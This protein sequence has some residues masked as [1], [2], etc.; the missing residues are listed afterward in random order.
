MDDD[1]DA[2]GWRKGMKGTQHRITCE[3]CG[4]VFTAWRPDTLPGAPVKC[5]F[6]GHSFSDE[7]AKRPPLPAPP[8]APPPAAPTAEPKADA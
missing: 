3:K 5:Y 4:K 7:A 6:C 8:A 1:A 2:D